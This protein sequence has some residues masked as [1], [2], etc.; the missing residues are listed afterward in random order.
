MMSR[1]SAKSRIKQHAPSIVG[2]GN[3]RSM[4]TINS[5]AL[6]LTKYANPY[7]SDSLNPLLENL[8]EETDIQPHG[9]KLT[10]YSIR[11]GCATMWASKGALVDAQEQLRHCELSTTLN[12]SSSP[13]SQREN[14][15]NDLW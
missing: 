6:W 3:E 10:W 15:A 8:R 4:R 12:Y 9:R 13:E 7:S 11:R 2:L 14:L 5:D 1:G